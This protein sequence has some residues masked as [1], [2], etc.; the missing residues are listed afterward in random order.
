M[1]R[2]IE[3]GSVAPHFEGLTLTDV[4]L[5]CLMFNSL[6]SYNKSLEALNK[7]TGGR[8]DLAIR[9]RE[10]SLLLRWLNQW[11]CR[12][13]SIKQHDVASNSIRGW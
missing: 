9:K 1:V 2:R 10:I 6:T 12:H 4:A 7:A 8:I 11:G 13:L 3:G 5:A